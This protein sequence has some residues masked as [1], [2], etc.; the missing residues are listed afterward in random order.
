MGNGYAKAIT[1]A[2]PNV[3]ECVDPSGRHR[4]DR[5]GEARGLERGATG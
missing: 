3:V 1:E 2:V 5:Q 4:G